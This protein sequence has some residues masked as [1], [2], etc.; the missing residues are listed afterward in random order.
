M[1]FYSNFQHGN[2]YIGDFFQVFPVVKKV[3]NPLVNSKT[4]NVKMV[5][6]FHRR[7]RASCRSSQGAQPCIAGM[8]ISEFWGLDI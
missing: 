4:Y 5:G 7:C 2:A 8:D 6:K 1:K 3:G